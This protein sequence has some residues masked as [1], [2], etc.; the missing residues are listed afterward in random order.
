MI[1]VL[2]NEILFMI[3]KYINIKTFSSIILLN[4]NH[5]YILNN[6][7]W[8]IIDIMLKPESPIPLNM[9]TYTNYKYSIDW[10]TI[11]FNKQIIPES[12]VEIFMKHENENLFYKFDVK[13]LVKYQKFSKE[14]I[15]KYYKYF[16][17]DDLIMYQNVPEELLENIISQYL[18]TPVD[19]YNI[20]INQKYSL[21]FIDKHIDDIVWYA[22][23]CNKDIVTTDVLLKYYD[24]LIWPELTKHGINED[25]LQVFLHKL[26]P[27]SWSNVAF[28]SKLSDSFILQHTDHLN[29]QIIFRS[30][31][32]QSDT[33]IKLVQSQDASEQIES[34]CNIALHQSLD[35]NFIYQHKH[36][37]QLTYLIRNPRIKRKDLQLVFL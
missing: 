11:I 36:N 3:F 32:L 27:I 37:L 34:W 5:F 33:I 8:D 6:L 24:F 10:I 9:E 15:L 20:L 12:V 14:F 25:I 16:Q 21:Q 13:L 4:K 35:Y 22:L 18:L 28:F 31:L 2:P 26:D 23:S 7:K 19:W 1:N 29:L 30:Q 17:F